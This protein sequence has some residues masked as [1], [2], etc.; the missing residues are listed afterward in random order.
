MIS[1]QATLPFTLADSTVECAWS[2]SNGSSIH[3]YNIIPMFA[4]KHA[5]AD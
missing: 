1:A 5:D 4:Q 3:K 2:P